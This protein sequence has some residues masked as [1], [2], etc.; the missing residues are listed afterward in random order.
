[1]AFEKWTWWNVIEYI[2]HDNT[3]DF[4]Y[5]Y[6]HDACELVC[7]R[8]YQSDLTLLARQQFAL[9]CSHYLNFRK[10]RK[11]MW[12]LCVVELPQLRFATDWPELHPD[13]EGSLP[14]FVSK[15]DKSKMVKKCL[16]YDMNLASWKTRRE[17]RDWII[18][19]NKWYKLVLRQPFQFLIQRQAIA[20]SL[21]VASNKFT[22]T[23]RCIGHSVAHSGRS[24]GRWTPN[25]SIKC[26]CG[27]HS[28][29]IWTFWNLR[30]LIVESKIFT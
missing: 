2:Q 17:Y 14:I 29:I 7:P 21:V 30:A 1:M 24:L 27:D 22:H 4:H 26:W 13:Y 15:A 25:W 8:S 20:A 12:K 28:V 16:E 18:Y 6:P 23:S 9:E 3:Y 10:V 19:L 11:E 5:H